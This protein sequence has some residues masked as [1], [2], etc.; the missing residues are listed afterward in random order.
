MRQQGIYWDK[1]SD[2]GEVYNSVGLQKPRL[3]HSFILHI[4]IEY[5]LGVTHV[6]GIMTD[7]QDGHGPSSPGAMAYRWCT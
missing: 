3:T 4:F 5:L 2:P 6:L 1:A 7:G